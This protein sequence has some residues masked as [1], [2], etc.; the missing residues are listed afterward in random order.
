MRFARLA[1]KFEGLQFGH[2]FF[3]NYLNR[4]GSM[5]Q[6]VREHFYFLDSIYPVRQEQSRIHGY[7]SLVR[8]GRGHI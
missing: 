1:R 7:P 5:H 4:S 3:Q 6:N 8:V 2:R